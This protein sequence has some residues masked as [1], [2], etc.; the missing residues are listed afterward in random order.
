MSRSAH[1]YDSKPWGQAIPK[2]WDRPFDPVSQE[3]QR[4][5]LARAQ[6]LSTGG[7][8]LQ[9]AEAI[10]SNVADVSSAAACRSKA[11][12]AQRSRAVAD[13]GNTPGIGRKS[14]KEDCEKV[15][16]TVEHRQNNAALGGPRGQS[17]AS[18]ETPPVSKAIFRRQ[19]GAEGGSYP[20]P[21]V[22]SSVKNP[23][24]EASSSASV[25]SSSTGGASVRQLGFQ[26]SGTLNP[27][28][29]RVEAKSPAAG[30]KSSASFRSAI[31]RAAHRSEQERQEAL[32]ADPSPQQPLEN[33]RL[34]G[35][36]LTAGGLQREAGNIE[37]SPSIPIIS[38]QDALQG[39][40]KQQDEARDSITQ[41]GSAP[42]RINL[43]AGMGPAKKE[44]D[45]QREDSVQHR[46]DESA[47]SRATYS[48]HRVS[49][50][51]KQRNDQAKDGQDVSTRQDAQAG[52]NPIW[53]LWNSGKAAT[54]SLQREGRQSA[55]N[56]VSSRSV[57]CS[58]LSSMNSVSDEFRQDS[59]F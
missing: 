3:I 14:A 8:P 59:S 16:P 49:G 4:S 54:E 37:G 10:I 41:I 21:E 39:G 33:E 35:S 46:E 1:S 55:G 7:S 52:T 57:R 50:L 24:F 19:L 20:T 58:L 34:E 53:K 30:A 44:I 28:F 26:A 18:S 27:T 5:D 45:K 9:K 42:T 25:G 2:L 15:V 23:L 38:D 13:A 29:E 11:E 47:E 56:Q 17:E 22:P 40:A 31:R 6:L 48:E 43:P 36:G 12:N 51:E 32:R